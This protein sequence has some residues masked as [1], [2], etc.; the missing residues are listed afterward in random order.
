MTCE[1]MTC[2]GCETFH[3]IVSCVPVTT[4]SCHL[5]KNDGQVNLDL[6][7]RY[8]HSGE[9]GSRR[10]M[11]DRTTVV[12]DIFR[13]EVPLSFRT[14]SNGDVLAGVSSS[15]PTGV[16]G[17]TSGNTGRK[18][19]FFSAPSS[20]PASAPLA[21]TV[22]TITPGTASDGSGSAFEGNDDTECTSDTC[23]AS[24]ET[25]CGSE[26]ARVG[27]AS[28]DDG[29]TLAGA[30]AAARA[31]DVARVPMFASPVHMASPSGL[32]VIRERPELETESTGRAV[33]H[34]EGTTVDDLGKK[35]SAR[36]ES[37][38]RPAAAFFG[39]YD[40]HD[41]DVVAEALHQKLH[42]LVAKQVRTTIS[43]WLGGLSTFGTHQYRQNK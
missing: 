35:T 4:K 40:G 7:V 18:K 13:A 8:G 6:G 15:E 14:R 22:A 1:L 29:A 16:G 39:V 21:A 34:G 12:G 2:P 27:H 33:G 28:S 3:R 42:T 23:I 24:T 19:M 41:G 36:K 17:V 5:Q 31:M 11:E 25:G 10:V 38:V 43:T 20:A 32:S 9:I 26:D 30:G 37:G